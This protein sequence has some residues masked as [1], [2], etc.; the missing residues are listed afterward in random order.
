MNQKVKTYL[1]SLGYRHHRLSC[2]H[3]GLVRRVEELES[4]VL[5]IDQLKRFQGMTDIELAKFADEAGYADRNTLGVLN[6]RATLELME[7]IR[8]LNVNLRGS[9]RPGFGEEFGTR[10][11]NPPQT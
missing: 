2:D 5:P 4:H 7:Q 10:T 3:S 9:R 8:E 1:D 11:V 6:L